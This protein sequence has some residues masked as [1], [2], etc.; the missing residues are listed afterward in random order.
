MRLFKK[1]T[2]VVS[3]FVTQ[4]RPF[5]KMKRRCQLQDARSHLFLVIFSI[6]ITVVSQNKK[7]RLKKE[8]ESSI[9]M[10]I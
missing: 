10:R 7:E 5:F 3:I 1:N 4:C 2:T 8:E 6:Y 9:N